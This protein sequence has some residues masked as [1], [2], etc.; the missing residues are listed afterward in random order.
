MDRLKD[1]ASQ[2]ETLLDTLEKVDEKLDEIIKKLT[3]V[4]SLKMQLEAA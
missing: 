2:A 1:M 3:R 4:T